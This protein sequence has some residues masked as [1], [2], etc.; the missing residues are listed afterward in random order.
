ML[1]QLFVEVMS[2]LVYCGVPSRGPLCG[3][4]TGLAN[5][6]SGS[7]VC[8]PPSKIHRRKAALEA[9]LF[10]SSRSPVRARDRGCVKTRCSRGRAQ[11]R[12]SRSAQD[13]RSAS[14]EGIDDPGNCPSAEFSHSLDPDPSVG[15]LQSFPMLSAGASCFASTKQ[16][17]LT[18]GR[19][20]GVPLHEDLAKPTL[21]AALAR[22]G[23][24]LPPHFR[25]RAFGLA[26]TG[27]RQLL[28]LRRFNV[29]PSADPG[30]EAAGRAPSP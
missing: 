15:S 1:R 9:A 11:S 8:R 28:L 23:S 16:P 30:A 19:R 6:G 12:P 14:R 22:H 4:Q 10:G 13:R 20:P 21:A 2:H 26:L 18:S 17:F 7:G 3:S 24:V 25:T 5:F 27:G 29:C